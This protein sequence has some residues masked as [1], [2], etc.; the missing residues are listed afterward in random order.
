MKGC[1]VLNFLGMLKGH[2]L[3]MKGIG[4]GT[5]S[6]KYGIKKQKA[7]GLDPGA[8]P[9]SINLCFLSPTS[10]PRDKRRLHQINLLSFFV[11]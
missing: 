7:K 5:F 4:K 3:S 9:L 1:K 10:H 2:H 8:E 6:V 11:H